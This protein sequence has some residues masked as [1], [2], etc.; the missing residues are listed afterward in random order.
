MSLQA[1]LPPYT[2]LAVLATRAN[3]DT[4]AGFVLRDAFSGTLLGMR[5][6]T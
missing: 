6:T 5:K 1:L 3:R 2:S 4:A